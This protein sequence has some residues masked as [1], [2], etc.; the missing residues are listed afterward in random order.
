MSA[1]TRR[2]PSSTEVEQ[3]LLRDAR[4]QD[5]CVVGEGQAAVVWVV[6][7]RAVRVEALEALLREHLGGEV[8]PVALIDALPTGEAGGPDSRA[9]ANLAPATP[10]RLARLEARLRE[11]GHEAVALAG[12][13]HPEERFEPL[14]ELFP[15]ALHPRQGNATAAQARESS[16]PVGDAGGRPSLVDSGPRVAPPGNPAVLPDALRRVVELHPDRTVTF[17]DT[18]GARETLRY[19]ELRDEALQLLGGLQARGLKKGDRVMFLLEKPAEFIRAF[20]ACTL[21]GVVPVPMAVPPS[22]ERT[23]AGMA[24]VLSVAERLGNP[25]VFCGA[26]SV[27]ALEALGM[28]ALS[29]SSLDRSAA[30]TPVAL[31]Q[32]DPAIL[33]FTS[34]STGRPKGVVLSHYNLLS[35]AG[36]MLHAGWY[37][38]QDLGLGWM[39]LDHVAGLE[40]IHLNS[41]CAG[42]SQIIVARDY[43][44]ADILRWMDLHSEFRATVSWAPNFAFG[45]VADRL[46]RGVRRP[47]DLSSVRVLGNAGEPI[48]AETMQRFVAPLAQDGLRQDAVCPMWGMAETSSV[49]TGARG[50]HTHADEPHVLLGPPL[51]GAAFRIVDDQ[52]TVVPEG[53]VGHLQV[54]GDP[55]LAG[56]L[57]DPPL[58]AQSFTKDGWFRTG[59]LAVIHGEQMAIAGRQ[60]E[61]LIVNGNNVYP[62][63]IEAVVELVPGVLPSYAAVA[64]TRVGGTQTDEVI[65][66]FVP[67]PGAPPLGEL[68]RSIR[69]AVGRALG[70]QVAYLVPLEKHQVPRTELGKRGRTELRRRFESGELASERRVAERLLGGPSTLPRCLAVPRWVERSRPLAREAS[71][72]PGRLLLVADE[73]FAS[74]L[75]ERLA[76]RREVVRVTPG[77]ARE[78]LSAAG[79]RFEEIVYAVG[80]EEAASRSGREVLVSTVSPLLELVQALAPVAASAPV[81]LLVVAPEVDGTSAAHAAP[82]LVPGLLWSAMAETAG[83]EARIVWVPSETR[84]AAR[85]VAGELELAGSAR[86][87]AYREG[88]RL[89]LGFSPWLP[90]PLAAPQRLEREGLYL[91]TGALGGVGQLWARY[92]RRSLGAKLLLVGRRAR[93]TVIEAFERELGGDAHY[94]SVDVTDAAKLQDVLRQ[95]EAR[96]GRPFSGAFHF[97][98]A[99]EASPLGRQTPEG[100][101]REAA[102]HALGAVSLAEAFQ[103]RPE[104]LL[105]FTSSLMG[106]LGAGLHASY[107]AASGFVDRFARVLA[108]QGRRAVTVSF[109][110]IRATGMARELRASPP[111]YRMLEPSQA[112]ASLVLA[113]ESGASHVLVG[114]EGSALPW[115]P[116]G[117]GAGE[118][119]EQAHVF[120]LRGAGA[121][122]LEGESGAVPHAVDSF[123][124]RPDGTVDREALAARELDGGSSGPLGPLEE[125]VV[126]AFREVLGVGDVGL[127]S[128]FFS[129]GGSSL[130]ATRVMARI[131]EATGLRLREPVLFENPS[132]SQLVAYLRR[133]VDVS[134]LDVSQLSDAQVDLLLRSLQPS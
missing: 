117:L 19:V 62:H 28:R 60:K 32:G 130:Q 95:A 72:S 74:A 128:G 109:S 124:R 14:D 126:D 43:I 81:R 18:E 123:P 8:P 92:L 21:G 102:A 71:A 100:L 70:I 15:P 22:L 52:D 75:G 69:E 99:L 26:S 58:N 80:R 108:L 90:A 67:A 97:A 2:V 20:W 41:L 94:V 106:T 16:A 25:L 88:R 35:M 46:A 77:R 48:V 64:P 10:A 37:T 127:R 57:D 65:V 122:S 86:E 87:L 113:V 3:L 121:P 68:L 29:L 91:V 44:L 112:V 1:T 83:L 116:A 53:T 115:R 133:T 30:G 54:R 59:D 11:S 134:Q 31:E 104:A 132:V 23:N 7:R 82:L 85:C 38:E 111:G 101:V 4:V 49:Y 6:P 96:H 93:D 17:I 84:E 98:G 24:R 42:T 131:N 36:G 63:E 78:V 13:N 118:P 47:W 12:P 34:G 89:E 61:L 50:V 107:C 56:Y 120:V 27:S 40:Y 51:A 105:V 33:S 9:L 45:L 129:L 66:F 114:V 119:L 103:A 125:V 79:A 5:A 73:A 55:V 110:A 39:P 76:G